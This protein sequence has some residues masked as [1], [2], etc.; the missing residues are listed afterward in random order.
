M[1]STT[2]SRRA[3]PKPMEAFAD[4]MADA[5][6]LLRRV[7]GFTNVRRTRM[8]KELRERV[9]TALRIRKSDWDALDCLESPD[10]F[11]TFKP[12]SRL[13]RDDFVD[14]APLLRQALVAGCAAFETYMGDCVMARIG[15]LLTSGDLP[16]KAGAIPLDRATWMRIQHGYTHQKRGLR[17]H[18]V[19]PYV[20]E[21]ASTAPNRVGELLALIGVPEWTR[22]I[23]RRRGL[24]RGTTVKDLDRITQR[25]NR[26]AH[27]GDRDG[28][29]R[30]HITLEYVAAELDIIT[31]VVHAIEA[32]TSP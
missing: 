27:A 6:H 4:N 30:A 8:R 3:K 9:G 28:R 2:T 23:D 32:I 21:R 7:E 17:K 20:Y 29:G 11:V 14:H 16:A 12:G 22:Q 13:T 15:P 5:R 31:E 26:I 25:R 19:E 1:P 18:V 24:E 10:A